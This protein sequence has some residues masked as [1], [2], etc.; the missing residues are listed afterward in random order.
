MKRRLALILPLLAAIVAWVGAVRAAQD[1]SAAAKTEKTELPL[2]MTETLEFETDEGT[3]ISLDVTP[4]GQAIVFE[5][6]GDLYR[7]PLAGGE[8]VRFRA[9]ASRGLGVA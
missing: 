5:L 2:E 6:L 3:W 9:D 1:R 7:V 4:D 8:A